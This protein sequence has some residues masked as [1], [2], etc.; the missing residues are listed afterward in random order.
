MHRSQFARHLCLAIDA[1]GYGGR[2][3]VGQYDLQAQLPA[4]LAEAAQA[5]GL[6]RSAWQRQEQ[7]DGEVALVPAAQPE[8]RVVDDLVRELD[9][10]LALLNHDRRSEAR[11]RVRVAMH[12]GVAY[13]APMGFAGEGVVVA[14]RI[15]NSS[16]L[17]QALEH[18]ADANVVVAV[19]DRVYRD[20]V[21][22]RHTSLREGDFFPVEI[23]EKEYAG[24][25]WIRV[26]SRRLPAGEAPRRDA[27]AP[28]ERPGAAH[29]RAP[30][31]ENNFYDQVRDVGVIGIAVN[32][33]K[34][35]GEKGLR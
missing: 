8:P 12:F 23:N 24:T 25:A 15:L 20:V 32:G 2:D 17:H 35:D 13:K 33:E 31:V 1:K 28:A 10:S 4:V 18:E 11:L 9:A 7:G 14:A 3:N 27:Q 21:L 34:V 5:A 26:L 29:A 22:P 19:S 16:G 6:D 30:R